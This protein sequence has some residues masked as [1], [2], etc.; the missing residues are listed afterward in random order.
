MLALIRPSVVAVTPG[1]REMPKSASLGSPYRDI[2]TLAGLT[3]RCRMPA[4]CAVSSAPAIC[5]PISSTSGQGSGPSPAQPV[6]QRTADHQVHHDVGLAG[7]GGPAAVH[8]DDVRVPGQP[9]HGLAFPDERAAHLL[10]VQPVLD[11]LH[12]DLAAELRFLGPVDGPEAAAADLRP[13]GSG[14]GCRAGER[15]RRSVERRT[16]DGAGR[17][18]HSVRRPAGRG[19]GPPRVRSS[20]DRVRPT[21]SR[22]K[23]LR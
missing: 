9:A 16:I 4:R 13:A 1:S 3:S 20:G 23:K 15:H 21:S 2:S 10:V 18:P 5:T 11:D 6:G 8:G 7:V 12:G 22:S 19:R 17:G 14:R